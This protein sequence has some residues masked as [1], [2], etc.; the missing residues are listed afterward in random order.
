[1]KRQD[2]HWENIFTKHICD[3]HLYPEYVHPLNNKK[4]SNP[5]K[6]KRFKLNFM[7]KDM[8]VNKHRMV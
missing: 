4:S 8:R 6:N 2:T 7:K 1:M 3:K 5:I